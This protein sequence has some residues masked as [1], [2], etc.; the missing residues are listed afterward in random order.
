MKNF[1]LR[2]AQQP[3]GRAQRWLALLG[4]VVLFWMVVPAA[5]L[6]L[7]GWLTIWEKLPTLPPFGWPLWLGAVL[8]LVGFLLVLWVVYYQYTQGEGTP[9]PLVP[10]QHLVEEGPFTYTRN[11]M[12]MGTLAIYTGLALAVGSVAM[13]LL[14]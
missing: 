5:L 6:W 11:A 1:L 13:L 8:M 12:Y 14:V 2:R 3:H 9:S 7:G 4:G 10:T